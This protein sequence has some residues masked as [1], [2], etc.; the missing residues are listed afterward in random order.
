MQL[1][2]VLSRVGCLWAVL[3]W[4]V[5]QGDFEALATDR[6]RL[7]LAGKPGSICCPF[8]ARA[9]ERRGRYGVVADSA[10]LEVSP[11]YL[12]ALREAGWQVVARSR[13]LNTVVV[14]RTDGVAVGDTSWTRFPFVT[15]V[16][17]VT[18]AVS[19]YVPS[20]RVPSRIRDAVSAEVLPAAV[21][22]SFRTPVLELRG[23]ALGQAGYR[24]E[25]MLIAVLDAGF[26]N[27]DR[28]PWLSRR[29]VGVRDL[30]LPGDEV[31]LYREDAH[32]AQCLSVMASDTLHGI[33]GTACEADYFLIR[34]EYSATESAFEEDLWVMGAEMADSL[35]A[36]LIS[37]SLGYYAFDDSAL[38]HPASDLG[39]SR[40]YITRGAMV[41]A[42]K[43]MLVC[44]AAGNERASAWRRLLFPGDAAG[45]L[46]VGATTPDREAATFSSPG[47]TVPYVKPDV[48][49]RGSR[50]YVVDCATGQ[51]ATGSGTSFAT[52]LMCGL[53]ASL[54]QAARLLGPA[55]LIEV[56]QRSASRAAA[57]DSLM[58][59]GMPDFEVALAAALEW[60][61]RLSGLEDV[62]ASGTA[63]A[64]CYDLTGRRLA[65]PPRQGCYIEGGRLKVV[66]RR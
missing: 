35:G 27:V 3:L 43:G 64:G 46:T 47:F 21:G 54:W 18:S 37:S 57:P 60:Q 65:F 55:Q 34:T 20:R 28:M 52:P 12:S 6:Y 10:D 38:D 19:G 49:C 26:L 16:E 63:P 30:Y 13:W 53:C 39:A 42:A 11:G 33:W 44:Q 59:Y 61:S 62:R 8:S 24:G 45:I 1:R 2:V 22:E 25:G 66:R 23:E 7:T 5:W 36:D 50:A 14:C 4:A 9:L 15:R 31:S 32:G 51:P 56:I 41:A 48:A 29:V 17:Q 58:G 40:A